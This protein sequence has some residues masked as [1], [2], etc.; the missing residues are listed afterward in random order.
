MMAKWKERAVQDDSKFL[1]TLAKSVKI[2]PAFSRG[3]SDRCPK[4][5]HP[6]SCSPETS[7]P[8]WFIIFTGGLEPRRP[9]KEAAQQPACFL[10]FPTVRCCPNVASFTNDWG[11]LEWEEEGSRKKER[12]RKGCWASLECVCN[13][14]VTDSSTDELRLA[15]T[16]LTCQCYSRSSILEG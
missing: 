14:V 11:V 12:E 3:N 4:T 15:V 5:W 7:N 1:R 16:Y 6:I 10:S 9:E 13:K 2:K 8:L